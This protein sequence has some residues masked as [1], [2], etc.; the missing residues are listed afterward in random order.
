MSTGDVAGSE[1]EALSEEAAIEADL[2][3]SDVLEAMERVE[4]QGVPGV[5]TAEA[6]AWN[7][8]LDEARDAAREIVREL[9]ETDDDRQPREPLPDDPL[10]RAEKLLENDPFD[11]E[12]NSIDDDDDRDG[13][14]EPT[15]HEP[16]DFGGGESTGVQQL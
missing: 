2:A 13:R 12:S 10:E 8:R 14:R 4:W 1:G 15:R 11:D 9:N 7:A 6:A 5:S 16:A 3:L